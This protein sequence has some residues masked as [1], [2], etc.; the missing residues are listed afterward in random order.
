MG[1]PEDQVAYTW[2]S[3]TDDI[4]GSDIADG[5]P[6]GT[7]I[8]FFGG[9]GS[10]TSLLTAKVEAPVYEPAPQGFILVLPDGTL[11]NVWGEEANA[12][13]PGWKGIVSVE[14]LRIAMER[15]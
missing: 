4:S 7:Q 9:I 5:I 1:R 15:V 2:I 6:V 11:E 10:R 8:A 12:N 13:L 14:D 3:H